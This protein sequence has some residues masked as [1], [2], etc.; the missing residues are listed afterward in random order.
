MGPEHLLC[1][2]AVQGDTAFAVNEGPDSAMHLSIY[3]N[4]A[5]WAALSKPKVKK[6]FSIFHLH[7]ENSTI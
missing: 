4:W 2:S 1:Q 7:D 3:L 5:L 6:Y